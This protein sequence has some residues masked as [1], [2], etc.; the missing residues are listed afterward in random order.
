MKRRAFL[1]GAAGAL[2]FADGARA[3]ADF[4]A[5]VPGRPI[6]FPE[7]EGSHP[8]FRTE[9]WYVTGWLDGRGIPLGFQLTFFRSRPHPDSGN[10]SRFSPR[11]II[12][13]HAAVSERA[14]GRLRH[15][16]RVARAGFGL[17]QA[18]SGRMDVR[19][20]DWRFAAEDA[21][22]LARIRSDELDFD[23]RFERTQPPLLQGDQGYSRKGPKPASASY[24]YSHP[25]LAV[26]GRL[27]LGKQALDAAGSA[28][29]DHEWSSEYLDPDAA[30]WDWIGINFDDGSALMAFRMRG[31]DGAALWAAATLRTAAGER[32]S[33]APAEVRWE[34]RRRWRSPRTGADYPVAPRVWI[35]DTVLDIEPLF[36]DQENDTRLTTGAVYWEGAVIVSRDGR[37]AG[38]GYLELTGYAGGLRL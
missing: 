28:W 24:Y 14:H 1:L 35:A 10:P 27:R 16:Q 20:D 15:A 38:R 26:S 19:L 29:L 17:A 32:R 3:A 11:E 6:R 8:E 31:K 22:Y 25:H 5:V 33:Y 4:A 13:A 34:P 9:W 23:L 7:D 37:R 30:G 2:G 36:D 12:I 21:R 18:A